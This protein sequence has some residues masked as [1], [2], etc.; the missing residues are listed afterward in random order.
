MKFVKEW[1]GPDLGSHNQEILG[2]RLGLT[3]K[4][5]DDLRFSGVI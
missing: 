2:A 1:A 5:L 3:D 4:E